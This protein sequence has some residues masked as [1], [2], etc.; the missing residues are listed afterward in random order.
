MTQTSIVGPDG[1]DVIRL[2]STVMRILEDGTTTDHRIGIGE[3]TV[4]PHTDGPPQHRHAEHDEGFYVVSG[5]ARF[6][7]GTTTYDA[8]AGTLAMVPPGA[9]HTFANPGDEPLVLLNTFTPDRYVQYFRDLRTMIE[10]GEA[11]TPESTA[12]VMAGYATDLA[13]PIRVT[14]RG[15]GAPVL[16]LHGGAGVDSVTGLSELLAAG[17]HVLTPVHPG[18]GGTPRPARLDSVRA[19]ASA[20]RDLLA[21]RDLTDVTV[22]GSSIGGW[23]A[24]ELAL[25]APDRV[26]K[27]VLVDAAGLAS[28]AHP[29]ADYFDMTLD[30]VI[31]I[32]YAHPDR[33]RIDLSAFTDEQRAI[34]A[35]NRAALLAYGGRDMADPT[36]AARLAGITVPTLVVWGEA[37]GM[38]TPAYGREYADAIPGARFEVLPDAGHLPQLET[39]DALLALLTGFLGGRTA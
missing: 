23:I 21:E 14:E 22:I 4:A 11:L 5:T 29:V 9:P 30:E 20:Y 38:V 2:G 25:C 1:G 19:L 10:R 12:R 8:P 32:S 13:E 39:P 3:I 28:A 6:T 15:T 36:L 37:D 18:F 24:A 34:A 31:D 17:H 26:G 35:G 16:V 33:H 7:V 27:L